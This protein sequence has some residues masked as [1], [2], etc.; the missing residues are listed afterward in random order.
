M[1][2]LPVLSL[3]G[4]QKWFID[5]TG[6]PKPYFMALL[7]WLRDRIESPAITLF[8]AGGHYEKNQDQTTAFCFTEGFSE[9]IWVP[10]LWGQIDPRKPWM[11]FFLLGFEGNRSIEIYDRFEPEYV[12]ALIGN[13]GYRPD[14]TA[15]AEEKNADFLHEAVPEKI[16]ANAADAIETWKKLDGKIIEAQ[17]Q[18]N[19]CIVPLGPKPHAL[20]GCLAC[21]TDRVPAAL[22]LMPRAYKVRDVPRGDLMWKYEVRL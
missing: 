11:Y 10:H 21:L 20:G 13:P 18:S 6:S 12:T 22:Y 4:N 1:R 7:A 17:E 3:K 19:I 8:H 14:Y 2:R 16:Y 9:F 15:I 5:I